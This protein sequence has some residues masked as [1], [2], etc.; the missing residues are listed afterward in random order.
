MTF[1]DNI[2]IEIG[3]NLYRL[4]CMAVV[5]AFAL[6][7]AGILA[8]ALILAGSILAAFTRAV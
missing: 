6:L 4:C 5:V 2:N 8:V 3:Q 7:G 1:P